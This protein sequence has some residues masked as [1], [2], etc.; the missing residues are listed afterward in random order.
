MQTH[1]DFPRARRQAFSELVAR[2]SFAEPEVQ[3]IG[4]ECFVRYHKAERGH[5]FLAAD[6]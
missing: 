6:S 4:R 2:F 5:H 3:S 1:D